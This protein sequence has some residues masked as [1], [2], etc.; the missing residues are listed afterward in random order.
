MKKY[1]V[2]RVY[3]YVNSDVVFQSD[4]KENA[5][6]YRDIMHGEHPDDQYVL[7]E[8]VERESE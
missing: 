7:A 5:K 2:I 3:Q 8:I 1:L 4:S 6:K